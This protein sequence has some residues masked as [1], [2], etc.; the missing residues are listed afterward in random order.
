MAQ[1]ALVCK[2]VDSGAVSDANYA[3]SK[4]LFLVREGYQYR[5]SGKMKGVNV[6]STAG[7]LVRLDW[8]E[9]TRD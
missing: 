2:N 1:S 4:M 7:C 9:G 6:P 5:A 3:D 8:H